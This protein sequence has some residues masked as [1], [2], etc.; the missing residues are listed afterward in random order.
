M[1][2]LKDDSSM[3][4]LLALAHDSQSDTERLERILRGY[5]EDRESI[6]TSGLP[7]EDRVA[8]LGYAQ[9]ALRYELLLMC[10]MPNIF[11]EN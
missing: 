3:N 1:V 5:E 4:E 7:L 8:A 11:D 6:L 10:K 9:M 2:Q